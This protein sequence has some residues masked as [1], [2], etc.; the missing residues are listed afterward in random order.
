[1]LSFEQYTTDTGR[2]FPFLAIKVFTGAD[3]KERINNVLSLDV[4]PEVLRVSLIDAKFR[5]CP[6][7]FLP[8]FAIITRRNEEQKLKIS[9][10]FQPG[11]PNWQIFWNDLLANPLIISAKGVGESIP[12]SFLKRI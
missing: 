12:N 6:P 9:Y 2:I 4:M 3:L 11:T 10:P 8:R 5:H 1:M 7:E